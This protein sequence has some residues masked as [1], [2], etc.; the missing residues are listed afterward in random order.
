MWEFNELDGNKLNQ[1]CKGK[2]V[3]IKKGNKVQIQWEQDILHE[4]YPKIS[5]ETLVKSRYN[6]HVLGKK[7]VSPG[8][9]MNL[10]EKISV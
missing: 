8:W 1:W 9:R 3:A 5:Q 10:D 7:G 4:C 6:K 2:V